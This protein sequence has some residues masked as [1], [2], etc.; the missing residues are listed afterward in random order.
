MGWRILGQTLGAVATA[1]ESLLNDSVVGRDPAGIA[2][3]LQR[4]PRASL[5]E[6]LLNHV[7]ASLLNCPAG[8][9]RRQPVGRVLCLPG[10]ALLCT[11][12]MFV[13]H[14]VCLQSAVGD[15][16]QH[17][18][19]CCACPTPALPVPHAAAGGRSCASPL[20]LQAA[21]KIMG[22]KK[23]GRIISLASVVG[24][25]GNAGQVQCGWAASLHSLASANPPTCLLFS[26]PP[27]C[28]GAQQHACY[29]WSTAYQAGRS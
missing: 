2:L 24:Q 10:G 6:F 13:L 19:Q 11:E 5:Q 15:R 26:C 1:D 9:D 20:R 4:P 17:E 18:R 22:K 16:V 21:A 25:I 28:L 3:Q 12:L 29:V 7:P 14:A 27:A 23:K 8:S